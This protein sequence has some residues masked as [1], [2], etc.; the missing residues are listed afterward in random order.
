MAQN[1][2]T[3]RKMQGRNKKLFLGSLRAS[4]A[5]KKAKSTTSYLHVSSSCKNNPYQAQQSVKF[6]NVL[7]YNEG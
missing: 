5:I 1:A 7:D 3:K 6:Q 4:R 2:R